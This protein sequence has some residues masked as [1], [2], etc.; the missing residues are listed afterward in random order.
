MAKH[1]YL[2]FSL[3]LVPFLVNKAK[4][5]SNGEGKLGPSHNLTVLLTFV[6]VCCKDFV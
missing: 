3:I 1:L 4:Q 6:H 5:T 2:A